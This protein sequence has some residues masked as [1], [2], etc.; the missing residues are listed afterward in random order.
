MS[1]SIY[2]Q[3]S[4]HGMDCVVY[5]PKVNN[6]NPLGVFIKVLLNLCS[7]IIAENQDPIRKDEGISNI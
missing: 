4:I 5:E 3:D 2:T 6:I 1:V 7:R